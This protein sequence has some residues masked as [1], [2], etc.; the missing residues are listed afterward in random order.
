MIRGNPSIK[1]AVLGSIFQDGENNSMSAEALEG[2]SL[3]STK[4]AYKDPGKQAPMRFMDSGG[5]SHKA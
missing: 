2:Y 1:M 4:E 3:S 5:E